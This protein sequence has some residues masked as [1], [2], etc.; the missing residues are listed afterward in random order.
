MA[1]PALTW[2]MTLA[3]LIAAA[4]CGLLS[5]ARWSA[6]VLQWIDLAVGLLAGAAVLLHAGY[7]RRVS[8]PHDGFARAFGP[9]WQR[10]LPAIAGMLRRRWSPVRFPDRPVNLLRNVAIW[11]FPETE[12]QL[13][14]DLWQPA[15]G[16]PPTGVAFLFFH[17]SAWHFGDKGI[18]TDPMCRHLAAQGHLVLDVAYRLA[19]EVN[20]AGMTT[21]VKRA[22]AWVKQNA[23]RLGVDPNR[24]VVGGASAGG[25]IALLAAYGGA[26]PAFT[27]PDLVG[28]D[29]RIAGVVTL[30]SPCD[31]RSYLNHHAGRMTIT[32]KRATAPGPVD[33]SGL[34][35]E[36]MMMN[37][38]GGM[39]DEVP[40]MFDLADA[41][42]H[43]TPGAPPALIVQ[44]EYDFITPAPANRQLVERLQQNG[45]PAVYLELP[46]TEHAWDV[47]TAMA[48]V[49]L[50]QQV[51]P[52]FLDSQY[53]PPTTAAL[54]DIERFLAYLAG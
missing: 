24:V 15:D 11:T 48:N 9:D 20:I 40:A 12:S 3:G 8:A 13:M 10:L 42:A 22:V 26:H 33:F 7:I 28:L 19:P 47:G 53:A 43:V 21:D 46:Q 54:Y 34:W 38:C 44:G 31:L 30:Y 5:F 37:L 32:G 16:T 50:H 35:G 1:Y 2:P 17:G 23:T 29:T 45:V 51:I 36:Q 6:P 41:R 4:L 18:G 25:H 52:A 49:T 39:P 14:A 27:P